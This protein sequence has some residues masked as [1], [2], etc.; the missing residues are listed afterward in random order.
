MLGLME[1]SGQ[2]PSLGLETSGQNPSLGLETGENKGP[3]SCMLPYG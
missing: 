2:N 3:Y 1:T